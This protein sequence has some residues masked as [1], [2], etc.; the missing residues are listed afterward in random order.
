MPNDL[1]PDRLINSDIYIKKL[2]FV[3]IPSFHTDGTSSYSLWLDITSG[4][5]SI[6]HGDCCCG[7]YVYRQIRAWISKTLTKTVLVYREISQQSSR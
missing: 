3:D 2:P 1:M 7:F 6:G 4:S 5:C